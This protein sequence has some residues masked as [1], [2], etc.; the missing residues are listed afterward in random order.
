MISIVLDMDLTA[1][2]VE[3]VIDKIATGDF[4]IEVFVDKTD[5]AHQSVLFKVNMDIP[6]AVIEPAEVPI[7]PY[8]NFVIH[9]AGG[10]KV[11]ETDVR[12]V[13]VVD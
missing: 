3:F 13:K 12:V 6:A 2:G 10:R 9:T 7:D 4:Q 5:I 11:I 8:A 1:K